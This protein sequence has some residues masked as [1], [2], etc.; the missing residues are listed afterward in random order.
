MGAPYACVI[1]NPASAN[2]ATGRHWP[3]IRAALERVL[4]RWDNQFTL[5]PGDATRL[6]R[7]AVQDGYEMIVSIGG[8]GTMNEVVTGLFKE[9]GDRGVLPELVRKDLILGSVRQGTGGDFARYLG[10]S[11]SLP[12]SVAHLS[13]DR[14][15]ACDVGLIEYAGHDGL[16]KRTAFL[17]I[18]S[19]GLSGVVDEKVNTTSK[20]FGGRISFLVGLGRALVS[21]KPQGVRVLV[22][23]ETFYEGTLVTCAVANGQYFG[24]GMRFAP[25]AEIDDGKLDVV[26][27]LRSGLREVISIPDLYSGKVAD[28]AS[29]RYTQGGVV[30]AEPL[31]GSDR[32]L[33]DIDGEQLGRLPAEMRIVPS[34]VRLKV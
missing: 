24:G 17:N 23:D 8:D 14:T 25:K 16:R 11:G 12:A 10:L 19:F 27:Q 30:R 26:A 31:S 21:Y 28:W 4:D 20:V 22:D 34:A 33:L 15:R 3:E 1:V 29:V 32:V 9:D 6:A 13:G 5:A 18:A 2:G 7:A